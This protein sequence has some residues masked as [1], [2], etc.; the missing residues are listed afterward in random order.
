MNTLAERLKIAREKTG[1]SQ[2]QLA[3]SI[4]VSQQS[5]AKIENGDTLQPRKIKE[6][7]NV[8][9]VSQK[10]LQLGIEE[11]ASLSDF[12]VGEAESAS[13]DPA[14]FA[15]IPVLDV[16]LSAGNGCEAEIVESVIDWFPIRRMDLRKAGVSATNARIVKIW[17]NSLLPVLNN[18]DHVAVDIAQ[19]NP[20]RDG[21]LYAVRDGVLLRVKVLINQP[22]G[23]LIIRSF[24]KDE[25][26]DEILTFNERRARIHIIGRVFWSSRSW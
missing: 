23:G 16:E 10:W 7:A 24:N 21:D 22:D 4:G 25:Y 26:P 18:G 11:N 14:I 2:A 17:G 19:T 12:V 5:V 1:L 13:L 20:I 9:G 8:L 3:E 6:I 15:Y